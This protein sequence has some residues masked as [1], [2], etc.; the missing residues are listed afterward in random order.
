MTI[1]TKIIKKEIESYVIYEDELVI[2]FLDINQFTKGH[3]IIATKREI[4]DINFISENEFLHLFKIVKTIS[5]V[6]FKTFN[7]QGLNILNNNGIVGGQ[8]VFHFHVH[9]IPRFDQNE[10][11]FAVNNENLSLEK[12]Y[13]K[14]IQK[15]IIKNIK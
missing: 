14:H 3:T 10:I 6:L 13:F 7:P 11:K 12:K 4:V 8:T 2:A 1:F 9:I 15:S 5:N